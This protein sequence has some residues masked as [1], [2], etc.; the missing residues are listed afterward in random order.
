MLLTIILIGACNRT[1][2][3]GPDPHLQVFEPQNAADVMQSL[4]CSDVVRSYDTVPTLS[5]PTTLSRLAAILVAANASLPPGQGRALLNGDAESYVT[6]SLGCAIGAMRSPLR[7]L[8]VPIK[9]VGMSATR[10]V[11]LFFMGNR[12]AKYRLDEVDRIVRWGRIAAPFGARDPRGAEMEVDPQVLF[13]SWAFEPG[14]TWDKRVWGQTVKQGAPARVTRGGLALPT[15]VPL[16][17]TTQSAPVTMETC[18][19]GSAATR[20][21]QQWI[22]TAATNAGWRLGEESSVCLATSVDGVLLAKTC[23]G[24]GDDH[25]KL[26]GDGRIRID[27]T[28]RCVQAACR[29]GG[30]AT[31]VVPP[32]P[33]VTCDAGSGLVSAPCTA[34]SLAGLLQVFAAIRADG[35]PLQG[36]PVAAGTAIKLVLNSTIVPPGG[37]PNCH[38]TD[39]P[40]SVEITAGGSAATARTEGNAE[41]VASDCAASAGA[42]L[43]FEMTIASLSGE[44]FIGV[45]S[46]NTEVNV[47]G[48]PGKGAVPAYAVGSHGLRGGPT[49]YQP[50]GKTWTTGDTLRITLDVAGTLSVSHNGAAPQVVFSGLHPGAGSSFSPA[51]W[52][53]V[54][55]AS[56]RFGASS[57]VACITA[58][59]ISSPLQPFVISTLYP[60]GA[61]SVTALGRTSPR[62]VGYFSPPANVRQ[63][64]PM[65]RSSAAFGSAGA[66]PP[67]GIFGV[68]GELA[69][70]FTG[71]GVVAGISQILAQDLRGNASVDVTQLVRLD[72]ANNTL[73]LPGSVISTHGTSAAT[74]G[75]LSE[76]G[77]VLSIV[78]GGR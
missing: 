30:A 66:L 42:P 78:L 18:G 22:P 46:N 57:S 34:G 20:S 16:T 14:D 10:E 4:G 58:T 13:D 75:D 72:A 15:V 1:S 29:V 2:D 8:R 48:W 64:I 70:A 45:V 27:G 9:D 44:M 59:S 74:P 38:Y 65:T 23:D 37:E 77:V 73:T 26:G 47:H 49:G 32:A 60:N 71:A 19:A 68:F 53:V 35:V 41:V 61:V 7:G 55:G 56:V 33:R 17:P 51:A 43:A 24:G 50:F 11:D 3:G 67:I 62:P 76:P 54:S 52:M 28:N 12:K 36:K 69:L 25:L 63:G 5:I 39:F 40:A 6:A 21:A 31:G